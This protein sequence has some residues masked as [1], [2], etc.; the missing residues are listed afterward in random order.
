MQPDR[1]TSLDA[2]DLVILETLQSDGRTTW[3]HLADLIGMTAPSA[4]ERVRRLEERGFIQGIEARLDAASLGLDTLGFVLIGIGTGSD[5]EELLEGL[6]Q[7][8][9]VQ[10]C[11][12]IAGEYDYLMKVRCSDP[13]ALAE[14]L[15]EK[16]RTLPCVARTNT[17]MVLKTVKETATV[18]LPTTP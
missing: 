3:A 11:H 2:T 4:T 7:L 16:V 14:L 1:P 5:Q 13:E 8:P 6:A 18:P 9:E 17:L 12:V 15:R 10:E